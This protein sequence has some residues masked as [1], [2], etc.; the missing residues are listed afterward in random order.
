MTT[1]RYAV[2]ITDL[3]AGVRVALTEQVELQS[4]PRLSEPMHAPLVVPFGPEH[5]G[6]GDGD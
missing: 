2:P 4:E 3:E 5:C 1:N 6:D